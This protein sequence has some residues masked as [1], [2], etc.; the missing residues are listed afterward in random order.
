MC[1]HARQEKSHDVLSESENNRFDDPEIPVMDV[2]TASNPFH[3]QLT[4]STIPNFH[5]CMYNLSSPLSRT[6]IRNDFNGDI[7][8]TNSTRFVEEEVYAPHIGS[9]S[10][11][12]S[13][14]SLLDSIAK[15]TAEH[16]GSP[17]EETS[18]WTSSFTPMKVSV[19]AKRKLDSYNVDITQEHNIDYCPSNNIA[20]MPRRGA[21]AC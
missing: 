19:V 9:F 4:T 17:E 18:N 21:E 14:Q 1:R 8:D 7:L 20:R 3:F 13:S 12:E 6:V 10:F 15:F 11:R 2:D 5:L 16:T